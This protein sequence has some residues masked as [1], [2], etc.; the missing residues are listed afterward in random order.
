MGM[1]PVS[2]TYLWK[3][4]LLGSLHDIGAQK[5]SVHSIQVSKCRSEIG[6]YQEHLFSVSGRLVQ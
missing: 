4:S 5:L 1:P 3:S 6:K 2:S